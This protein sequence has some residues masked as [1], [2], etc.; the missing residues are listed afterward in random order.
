MDT[1][2]QE[3]RQ[4]CLKAKNVVSEAG[5]SLFLATLLGIFYRASPRNLQ[6]GTLEVK[7]KHL[8]II[9]LPSKA[10]CMLTIPQ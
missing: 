4:L 7:E 9:I 3:E 1:D 5:S 2:D 6:M 10:T 8:S